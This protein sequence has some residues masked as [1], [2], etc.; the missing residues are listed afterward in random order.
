MFNILLFEL[1]AESEKLKAICMFNI[2]LFEL[3]AESEK[4]KA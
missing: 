3:K 4:H 1:K 2:L